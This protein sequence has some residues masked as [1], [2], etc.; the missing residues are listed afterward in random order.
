MGHTGGGAQTQPRHRTSATVR[1]A[2]FEVWKGSPNRCSEMHRSTWGRSRGSWGGG[3]E[4]LG[5]E[6]LKVLARTDVTGQSSPPPPPPPPAILGPKLKGLRSFEAFLSGT[7]IPR[8]PA[9]WGVE[10]AASPRAGGKLSQ[11]AQPPDTWPAEQART[12]NVTVGTL[13]Q[14]R[15]P[16]VAH[17]TSLSL[18]GPERRAAMQINGVS[19]CSIQGPGPEVLGIRDS[20]PVSVFLLEGSLLS[21]VP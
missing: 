21:R 20:R 14:R 13:Y 6:L 12:Q 5:L 1:G 4:L 3:R 17:R 19:A 10:C 15:R 11:K 8:S 9:C 2:G 16:Q 7:A 18:S